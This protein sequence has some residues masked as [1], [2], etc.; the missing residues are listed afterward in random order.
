MQQDHG[1]SL[2]EA[3][4]FLAEVEGES[5]D[6]EELDE[7]IAQDYGSDDDVYNLESIADS[8]DNEKELI[9]VWQRIEVAYNK[10]KTMIVNK[11]QNIQKQLSEEVDK[12]KLKIEKRKKK[13]ERDMRKPENIKLVDKFA[14]TLGVI[15]MIAT[16]LILAKYPF[17]L[18]RFYTI[19]CTLL[20]GYRFFSYHGQG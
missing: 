5:Y 1:A 16:T 3:D 10:R 17:F 19:L 20:L 13:L 9:Q 15:I 12:T 11:V 8:I 6:R 4:V 18:P 7:Y 14:F 2:T